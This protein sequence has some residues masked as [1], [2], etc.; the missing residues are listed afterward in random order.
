M[1]RSERR[2]DGTRGGLGT[3]QPGRARE[4]ARRQAP[5]RPGRPR[6]NR[7]AGVRP[8]RSP[9]PAARGDQQAGQA[10]ARRARPAET[11]CPGARPRP[12]SRR[13]AGGP[14]RAGSRRPARPGARPR[15]G[16]PWR[17][18][19]AERAT[20][21]QPA[22]HDAGRSR[23]AAQ[24]QAGRGGQRSAV[25]R[26][27]PDAVRAAAVRPARR[28]AHLG[29]GDQH[30]ARRGLLQDQQAAG[31]DERAGQAA[32]G[33]GGPGGAGAVGAGDRG[34]EPPSS[35]CGGPASCGSSTSR[36]ARRP[37]TGRPG[38]GPSTL[39]GYAP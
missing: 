13:A 25:A 5:D 39:P 9:P 15:T 10:A 26:L 32:A 12:R 36:P 38:P 3:M 30:H 24:A 14:R 11:A 21:P 29:A 31:L 7:A 34:S 28:R 18:A 35:A 23:P 8:G 1:A 16:A 17:V 37:T 27:A 33:A 19:P 20:G 4:R 6:R 22:P 2:E